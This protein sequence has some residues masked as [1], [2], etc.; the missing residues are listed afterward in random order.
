MGL[1]LPGY[2]PRGVVAITTGLDNTVS[3]DS[4]ETV[5]FQLPFTAAPK[6][7]YKVSLRVGRADVDG[8]GDNAGDTLRYA[9]NSLAVRCRWASGSTVTTSGT[10]L[11][12][13]RVTV[14]DDDST[15][16]TGVSAHWFL[17]DPPAGQL[18]VGVSIWAGR[19]AATYGNVRILADGHAHFA[20]EDVGPYSA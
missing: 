20:V 11:G 15:T 17:L 1:L 2:M 16:A 9:K 18:T 5:V 13:Y 12:D 10:S 4:T 19:N 7:I 14:F 8:V 3:V 6:R